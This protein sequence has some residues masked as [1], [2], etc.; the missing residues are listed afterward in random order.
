MNNLLIFGYGYTANYLNKI[1]ESDFDNIFV[2]SRE[3][4]KIN[5]NLIAQTVNFNDSSS[6][7][8]NS[9]NNITHIICSIPPDLNGDPAFLKFHKNLKKLS[10]LKWI[11]YL[12]A[13]SVYGDHDGKFVDENSELKSNNQR[14]LNRILA[15]E[16][17]LKFCDENNI[18]L[19]IFRIAGIYGP[20]RNIFERIKNNEYKL[21]IKPNHF[22]SRIYIIDLIH[23]IREAMLR[24]EYTEIYN[25][26]DDLPSNIQDVVKYICDK[27]E[28][29]KP[30]IINFEKLEN[31]MT[32]SFYKDNKKV[33]NRLIK[34]KFNISL[35]FPTYREGYD[36]IIGK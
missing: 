22:F 15:E 20:G 11:G 35:K 27:I 3:P 29:E 30:D 17:W 12:S 36:E 10:S 26:S 24:C 23:C 14:G 2:T 31:E 1:I 33:N 9:E 25:V 4:S 8:S 34:K 32:R 21:V 7:L 5:K 13:T 16:Q 28:I 6:I 18:L 19:N